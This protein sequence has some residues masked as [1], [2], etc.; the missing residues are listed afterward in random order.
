MALR[1]QGRPVEEKVEY[2]FYKI[3]KVNY[4]RIKKYKK[5]KTI[6]WQKK[7]VWENIFII[8]A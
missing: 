2:I 8:L 5:P 3:F 6:K 1:E 4:R 7:I